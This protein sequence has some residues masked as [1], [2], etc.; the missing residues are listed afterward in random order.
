MQDADLLDEQEQRVFVEAFERA[1][2]RS[3]HYSKALLSLLGVLVAVL[4]LFFGLR[5]L[6]APWQT[7]HQARFRS[8]I[9]AQ[10]LA[11]AELAGSATALLAVTAVLSFPRHSWRKLLGA[12][13][14]LA[15][16]QAVF[17]SVAMLR[18][19]HIEEV[20]LVG[21]GPWLQCGRQVL[22]GSLGLFKACSVQDGRL[23]LR[24]CG[25][26][27]HPCSSWRVPR[28]APFLSQG[29][30]R[31][32][33]LQGGL[34]RLLWLPLVP[35]TFVGLMA[36]ACVTLGATDADLRRLRAAQYAYKRA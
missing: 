34:W 2:A 19:A 1:A 13:A 30:P 6:A 27:V 35:P 12:A 31:C 24:C 17:W 18:V 8:V 15:A 4:Y 5:Q 23:L 29:C 14:G 7:A 22:F 33:V 10:S 32:A 20:Q 28:F 9:R 21:R 25:A 3:A 16:L 36:L 11:A 26:H